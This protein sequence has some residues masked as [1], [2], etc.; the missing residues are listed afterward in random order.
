MKNVKNM[1][2]FALN[3]SD[4]IHMF[5][6]NTHKADAFTFTYTIFQLYFNIISSNLVTSCHL[7]QCLLPLFF[8]LVSNFKMAISIPEVVSA[9][10][11]Q[12]H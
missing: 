3:T 6:I 11:D 8:V 1:C 4:M 10:A 5:N 2:I 12:G 7:F 9:H